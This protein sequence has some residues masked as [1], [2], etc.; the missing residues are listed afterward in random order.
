MFRN[1]T[2]LCLRD[3]YYGEHCEM[4]EN[5]IIIRQTIS[6]SFAFIVIIVMISAAIFIIILDLLKY[7]CGIDPIKKKVPSKK[8]KKKK[9]K[10]RIIIQYIYV[11]APS[12]N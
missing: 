9:K 3:S 10:A 8:W 11:N 2:C 7:C 5:H 6:R 12:P 4:T 1:Y